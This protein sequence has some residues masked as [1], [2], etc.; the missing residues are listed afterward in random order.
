MK[1]LVILYAGYKSDYCSKELLENI[2]CKEL[3]LSWAFSV[4]DFAGLSIYVDSEEKKNQF[5]ELINKNFPEK[6]ELVKFC[7]N[8]TWKVKDLISQIK[9]D[10]ENFENIVYGHADCPFYNLEITKKLLE[11]H[12]E[13]LAEY[14]F[15]DGYPAGLSPEILH[16]GTVKILDSLCNLEN[17]TDGT[18]L[19]SV[20]ISKQI[21]K[22]DS[23]FELLKTDINSFEIET[24]LSDQDYRENRFEFYCDSKNNFT[25]CKNFAKNFFENKS[26]FHDYD[27]EQICENSKNSIDLL[28]VLPTFYNI[29]IASSCKSTCT[30]CPYPKCFEK[31]YSVLPCKSSEFMSLEN[32]SNLIDKIAEFS[33]EA[34]ISLSLWGE[35]TLHPQFEKFIEKVL[36]YSGLSLLIELSQLNL[37]DEKL[38]EI[39]KIVKNSPERT[40]GKEKIYWIVS[41]DACNQDS[42]AK[43]HGN[44]SN[45]EETCQSILKLSSLFENCV[46]PQFM[47]LQEN[48]DSLE[49]FYRFWKEKNDGK[50]I[51]QKYDNFAGY[52]E[53][54]KTADL[55]PI[56]RN[57][58]WHLRR[59]FV[60][61]L[62]GDVSICREEL[63]SGSQGNVFSESLESIWAKRKSFLEN[64][65]NGNLTSLCEKCDE[66]YTFNF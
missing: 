40:N 59:D 32:F 56:T 44:S 63:L 64:Y 49:T 21:V 52:L 43:I 18:V 20:E 26:N 39:E 10:S 29:Q 13:S 57:P 37:S 7:V 8:S 45:F 61:L 2:T 5:L 53:D 14:C 12:T 16:P 48:E 4:W 34:V 62:N 36:S 28:Q 9:V 6:L 11:L 41:V 54:K 1:N 27:I 47:R 50:L 24:I 3:S 46:Y 23:I 30:Y 35:A 19:K 42:Y 51:I 17:S 15:A 55:T 65:V 66:Y 31:K 58:C 33:S 25:L 38:S 60:I 22:R